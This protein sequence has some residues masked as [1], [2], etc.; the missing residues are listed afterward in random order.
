[1]VAWMA[2]AGLAITDVVEPSPAEAMA[3]EFP[4]VYAK[5]SAQPAFLLLVAQK[6]G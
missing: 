1:M 2:G 3:H 5:L 4:E 6:P